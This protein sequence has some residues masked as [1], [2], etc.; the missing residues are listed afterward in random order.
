MTG[1]SRVHSQPS[2]LLSGCLLVS[3]VFLPWWPPLPV[4]CHPWHFTSVRF[5]IC[6]CVTQDHRLFDA[7]RGQLRLSS[8]KVTDPLGRGKSS[9]QVCMSPEVV[10]THAMQA[11]QGAEVSGVLRS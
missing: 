10:T 7:M 2:L 5:L 9:K 8:V 4:P 3:P 1:Y 6:S 11:P